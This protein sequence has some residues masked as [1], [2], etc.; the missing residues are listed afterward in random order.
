MLNKTLTAI[1]LLTIASLLVGFRF[2]SHPTV[3][4]VHLQTGDKL[5]RGE[6]VSTDGEFASI[7]LGENTLYLAYS[8]TISLE[9]IFEDDLIVTLKRGRMV[10]D[11]HGPTPLV[12]ETNFTESLLHES[13]ATFINYDFL[14]TV[15]VAP[16]D[17]SVQITINDTG[18]FLVTPS[19]I[20]IV[21]TPP[22][23][24]QAIEVN[25]ATAG[26]IDFYTWAG[27]LTGNS[28]AE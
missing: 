25:L 1:L 11:A 12:I 26:V 4:A 9:R 8:T 27:A 14:E 15:H 3:T 7:T 10:V 18:E 28:G 16:I 20:A 22:I 5:S 13:K 23:T 2:D 17:S 24:Y 19:A 6:V 21:E